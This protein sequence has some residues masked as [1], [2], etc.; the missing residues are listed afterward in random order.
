MKKATKAK[1][2]EP[3]AAS[4]REIPELGPDSVH[5]GRGAE[6]LRLA[7]GLAAVT[8]GRPKAG[9]RPAG[10]S[11]RTVRLP[12]AEWEALD[13]LAAARKT[14]PHA[15][16]REAIVQWLARVGASQLEAKARTKKARVRASTERM[17]RAHE[18]TLRKLAE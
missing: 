8:R 17:M 14:T 10:S 2:V 1:H 3:S 16:M 5:L 12:D 9:T 15:A 4:L 7:R 13:E 18:K 11:A 6:G